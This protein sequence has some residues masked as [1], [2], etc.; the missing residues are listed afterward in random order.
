MFYNFF[1]GIENLEEAKKIFKDLAKKIHPDKGGKKEDFQKL[2]STF[3]KVILE[4]TENQ[5][6]KNKKENEEVEVDKDLLNI[7]N[8][9]IFQDLIIIE[10]IGS[11]LWVSGETYNIK[12]Q[13][14]KLGFKW[15][16]NKK[17]WYYTKQ[18]LKKK[19]GYYK[20]LED[21]KKVYKCNKFNTK[22]INKLK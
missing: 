10:L 7:I 22:T 6:K 5:F 4:F 17:S 18:E 8:Q 1:Q 21:I 19:R 14:K 20:N 13:L 3:E 16:K 2:N 9:L 15:S 11:W 12:D